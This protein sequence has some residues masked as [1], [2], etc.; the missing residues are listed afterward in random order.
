MLKAVRLETK[1]FKEDGNNRKDR[2]IGGLIFPV[3]VIHSMWLSVARVVL[4]K[5]NFDGIELVF[6]V[7]SAVG[8]SVVCA[9]GLK[10]I[11]PRVADVLFGGR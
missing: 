7:F 8:L 3:Y 6:V 9:V 1:N 4:R 2:W 10:W 5:Q 11:A